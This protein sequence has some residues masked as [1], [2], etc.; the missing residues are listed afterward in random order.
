L[1]S[2]GRLGTDQKIKEP[3]PTWAA[4]RFFMTLIRIFGEIALLQFCARFEKISVTYSSIEIG[5]LPPDSIA[6]SHGAFMFIVRI[7]LIL[8]FLVNALLI[9]IF[10]AA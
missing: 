5:T 7:V 10:L 3:P 2:N 8:S 6:I 9:S 1:A 4:A